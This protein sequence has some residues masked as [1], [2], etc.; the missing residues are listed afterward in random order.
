VKRVP[1]PQACIA[2]QCGAAIFISKEALLQTPG[3]T[4]MLNLPFELKFEIV[5][6]T[7]SSM[8]DGNLTTEAAS[9]DKF[10]QKM[11]EMIKG[12]EAGRKL[13]IEDIKVKGPD[14]TT[15]MLNSMTIVLLAKQ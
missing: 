4:I 1:D 12:M 3:L 6:F 5:S 7:M 10:T 13:Y 2:N 14:G 15:R 8:L 11:T 9:G